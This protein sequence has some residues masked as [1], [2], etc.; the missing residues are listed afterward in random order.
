MS[1]D[2]I[3][4][5]EGPRARQPGPRPLR[6]LPWKAEKV[7]KHGAR[8]DQGLH[9]PVVDGAPTDTPTLLQ[10][11]LTPIRYDTTNTKLYV[12][13]EATTSWLGVTVA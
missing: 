4:A 12:W 8:Y 13:N 7:A 6:E 5:F 1:D 9:I 10:D 3:P 2:Q 11:D